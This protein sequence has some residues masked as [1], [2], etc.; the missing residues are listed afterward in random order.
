[1]RPWAKVGME[2]GTGAGMKERNKAKPEIKRKFSFK[3]KTEGRLEK[4]SVPKFIIKSYNRQSR[5][6]LQI[7]LSFGADEV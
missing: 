2:R 7:L 6:S 3:H 5:I 4:D 1:M